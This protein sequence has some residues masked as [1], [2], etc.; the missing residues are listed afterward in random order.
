MLDLTSIGKLCELVQTLPAQLR[1]VARELNVEPSARI[2]GVPYYAA[3]D[4]KT[5]IDCITARRQQENVAIDEELDDIARRKNE[6]D[7]NNPATPD[8]K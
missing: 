5:L 2:D 6:L 8:T 3:A 7:E 4:A 1:R